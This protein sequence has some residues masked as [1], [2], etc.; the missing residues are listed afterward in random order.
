MLT[1]L[2]QESEI[3]GS[4][5]KSEY[6][7]FL[8]G[9]VTHN[10]DF[11]SKGMQIAIKS[12]LKTNPHIP[13]FAIV[14]DDSAAVRKALKG[15]ELIVIDP[16]C[17]K[18]GSRKDLG[19]GTYY[20]FFVHH[21]KGY[22]KALYIDGDTV[23][24]GDLTPVFEAEGKLAMRRIRK[25]LSHD[26]P[27]PEFIMEKENV[28]EP[29][30]GMN[31]GVMLFDMEYW[32]D[33]KFA[34]DFLSLAEEY[35]WDAFKNPCQG[36]MNILCWRYG[37]EDHLSKVYN[38]FVWEVDESSSFQNKVTERGIAYP[39]IKGEDVKILHYVGR[40]KPWDLPKQ[41]Y[42]SFGRR[43]YRYYGQFLPW[44]NH[45]LLTLTTFK[46]YIVRKFRGLVSRNRSA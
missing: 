14:D 20:R 42:F 34:D 36:F 7:I 30:L 28:S 43:S 11:V 39:S 8:A 19:I 24:L 3:K 4:P 33:G 40:M 18:V 2:P 26:F 41:G 16:A 5:P 13:V 17:M 46:N 44:S 15:C 29:V 1:I 45:V 22:K 6:C 37:I 32:Q 31:N 25:R 35:G 27:N 12:C 38:T 10:W 21:L 9:S 23:V